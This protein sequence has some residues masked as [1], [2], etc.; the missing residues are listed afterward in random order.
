MILLSLPGIGPRLG[1]RIA[2]EIGAVARF[3]TP[4]PLARIRWPG[5]T[6]WRSGTSIRSDLPSPFGNHRLKNAFFLAAFPSLR[7]PPS[8]AWPA[9]V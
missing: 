9:V 7:H 2:V 3:P 5:P 8:S 1:T 4:A 6:P